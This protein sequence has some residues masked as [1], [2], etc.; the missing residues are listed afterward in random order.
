MSLRVVAMFRVSTDSQANHGASLDA[1]ARQFDD[2][3]KLRG[4]IGCDRIRGCESATK[5]G[6]EREVLQATMQA[7]RRHEADAVW[8]LEASRLTRGDELE[9]ALLHR[10]LRERGCKVI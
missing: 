8:V 4:W 3:A 5:A 10:E 9:V 7:I 6:S 2:L 1:Q